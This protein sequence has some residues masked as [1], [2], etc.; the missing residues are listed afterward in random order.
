MIL[1]TFATR[2]VTAT[3]SEVNQRDLEGRPE[4]GDTI[5]LVTTPQNIKEDWYMASS[6][7]LLSIS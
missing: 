6:E 1:I 7:K 4:V 2:M 5:N 3:L